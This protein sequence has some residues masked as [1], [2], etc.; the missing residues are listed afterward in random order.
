[1]QSTRKIADAEKMK[2]FRAAQKLSFLLEKSVI[3]LWT[4]QNAHTLIYSL[5]ILTGY[6]P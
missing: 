5:Q 2:D 6:C 1:M 3:A 4:R